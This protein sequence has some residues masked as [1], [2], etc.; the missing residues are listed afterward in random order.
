MKDK[1]GHI[2]ELLNTTPARLILIILALI[3]LF[4]SL[5]LGID[6]LSWKSKRNSDNVLYSYNIKK[7]YS[8]AANLLPNEFIDENPQGMNQLYISRLINNFDVVMNY[9]YSAS[10]PLN[11][12]YQYN[13]VAS[14]VGEYHNTPDGE[15]A[16]VWVKEFP[17]LNTVEKTAN[18]SNSFNIQEK[19]TVDFHYYDNYVKEF[20][21]QI[22]VTIDAYLKLELE[23]TTDGELEDNMNTLHD[24]QTVT[25]KIPLNEDV[26][27]ISDDS[28]ETVDKNISSINTYVE[29]VN[30]EKLV[31]CVVMLVISVAILIFVL[32]SLFRGVKKDRYQNQKDKILKDY[33]DIIV[34]TTSPVN[35]NDYQV[36]HVKNFNE[37]I[38]LEEELHVPILYFE[39]AV[40]QES[41]FMLIHDKVLYKYDLKQGDD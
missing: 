3:L 22:G 20:M 9:S 17:V 15:K 27:A 25:M 2:A 41:W 26:F 4:F 34:E 24:T 32:R 31:I 14:I 36:I 28:N 18:N 12:K 23:V 5:K 37:M 13:I 21:R 30:P 16:E 38:D 10:K 40:G 8:Y 29:K 11:L 39:P 35:F 1:K 19:F 6:S 33:G 7:G